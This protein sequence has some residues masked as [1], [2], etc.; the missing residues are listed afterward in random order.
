MEVVLHPVQILGEL[1][2][3]PDRRLRPLFLGA[4]R[5][6]HRHTDRRP[7]NACHHRFHARPLITRFNG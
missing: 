1:H 5:Q 4:S 6:Q 2:Q 7:R 3:T